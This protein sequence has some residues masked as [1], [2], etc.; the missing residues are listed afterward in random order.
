[1]TSMNSPK[2]SPAKLDLAW[3]SAVPVT[4]PLGSISASSRS[5]SASVLLLASKAAVSCG[6]LVSH[7]LLA[8]S[9]PAAGAP[10]SPTTGPP[11]HPNLMGTSGMLTRGKPGKPPGPPGAIPAPPAS[12]GRP[13]PLP[14]AILPGMPLPPATNRPPTSLGRAASPPNPGA[15]PPAR[16]KP[17]GTAG[18]NA[19][20]AAARQG[21][22]ARLRPAP[23]VPEAT[24]DT[25]AW[26][27]R[28]QA[29]AASKFCKASKTSGICG[30]EVLQGLED[31]RHL[32]P[33]IFGCSTR[34]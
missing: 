29:S 10:K 31:V 27:R 14:G 12:P 22:L 23:P 24:G 11:K 2:L 8:R 16:F 28:R 4:P 6:V 18:G 3:I 20:A 25:S 7:H 30:L 19:A 33:L 32:R 9:A 1:M 5:R 34:R 13:A 15:N 17:P 21:L 26:P